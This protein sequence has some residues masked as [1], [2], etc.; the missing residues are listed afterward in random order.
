MTNMLR[1]HFAG[2]LAGAAAWPGA[3]NAQRNPESPKVG[4]VYTGSKTL[5]PSRINAVVEGLRASG[6]APAQ[7]ELV[8]RVTDSDP[9]LL[10][11][12]L[13]EVIGKKVSVFIAN[14]PVIL[15]AA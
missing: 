8:V 15:Q 4:Y 2:L 3:A 12:M 7:V 11:P 1:R 14:G 5:A 10:A 9:A 6:F 13:A